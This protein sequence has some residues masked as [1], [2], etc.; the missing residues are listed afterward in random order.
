MRKNSISQ[1]PAQNNVRNI[2]GSPSREVTISVVVPVYNGGQPFRQC[3]ISLKALDPAPMEIIVVADG[4]TDGSWK[5]A[6]EYG[7][8]VIR[9]PISSGGPARPRNL[10]ALQAKGDYLFF[11]D[12]DVCLPPETVGQVA[13]IFQRNPNLTALMGSYDDSPG[14]KNFLSQYKNLLHHYVHQNAQTDASTFWGACG[15]IRRE[16]FLKMGGFDEEFR[17]PSIEDIELGYRL[18]KAGHQIQLCKHITVKHLKRWDVGS[19][20]K[21]DFFYRAIPWTELILRD[22]MFINDL[23]IGHS[24]RLCVFLTYSLVITLIGAFWWRPSLAL[25][26][27]IMVAL[28]ITNASLYRFYLGKRGLGF[29]LQ[30]IPWHWL[31]YLYSG[32]A[33]ILGLA[34]H[35]FFGKRKRDLSKASD[36]PKSP[37]SIDS[38]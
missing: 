30:C 32:L 28:L 33:F 24:E 34:R 8:R 4:D 12:A 17:R 11:V 31:Y 20:L 15:A 36:L 1:A 21:A 26:G 27:L 29:A 9:L 7:F 35:V 38:P 6:E 18:R 13:G 10:G 25:A 23:N 16:V 2:L 22:R 3:L 5:M 14:E 19:L 37:D